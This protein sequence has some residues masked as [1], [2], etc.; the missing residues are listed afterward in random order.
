M[1]Q[2]GR[3]PKPVELKRL[4]A[5]PGKRKL[6]SENEVV[7][8]PAATSVPEPSRPLMKYGREVWD[9]VWQVGVT[10]ISPNTDLELLLM[11]CEMVDE[12]WNL[13]VKVMQ[14]DD[15]K[16]RRGLRELDRLIIGNLSLLGF[17]PTDR[18]RLGWAE[19][20]T[21]SRLEQIMTMKRPDS[22]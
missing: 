4:T 22:E 8:L 21:Q 18:S 5:N 13:R 16:L 17:T 10:W 11:T 9:T 12:R 15:S 14:T 6:P 7:L 20:K 2:M 1:A 19:V 3:P